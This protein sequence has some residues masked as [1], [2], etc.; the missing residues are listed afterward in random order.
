MQQFRAQTPA[1]AP[2]LIVPIVADDT[3][4]APWMVMGDRQ[5]W[6]ATNLAS[7]LHIYAQTHHLPWYVAGLLPIRYRRP[8]ERRRRQVAPDV[9]VAVVPQRPRESYDLEQEGA[10]PAFVVDVLSQS[11]V[12]R[13]TGRKRRLYE[14]LGAQEYV[15]FAPEPSCCRRRC[16]ATGAARTVASRL[17]SLMRA[18]GCGLRCW[19]CGS[20]PRGARCA[21]CNRMGNSCS[22]TR[23]A[24]RR[25][26]GRR[27]SWP[28]C[29]PCWS[30]TK[31]RAD[32]LLTLTGHRPCRW[33]MRSI[34]MDRA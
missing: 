29:V 25:A 17:C 18:G 21:R 13:D 30:T 14:A 3:E 22:P 8:G 28:G 4:E 33:F 12:A 20:W 2:D 16:K 32:V 27:R 23:R 6:S 26:R 34:C 19:G 31:E 9:M 15:L 5:F 24:K 1:I 10:F 11:S 7:M